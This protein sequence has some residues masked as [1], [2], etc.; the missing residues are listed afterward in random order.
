MPSAGFETT[1]QAAKMYVL[2]GTATAVGGKYN[3]LLLEQSP[4]KFSRNG[5]G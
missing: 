5:G 3:N 4:L 2:D 1:I